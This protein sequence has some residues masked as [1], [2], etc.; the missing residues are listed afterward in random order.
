M[1][2][3]GVYIGQSIKIYDRVSGE[4]IYGRIPEGWVV[5]A[6]SLPAADG[7]DSLYYAV[8]V[9]RGDTRTRAKTAISE[10]LMD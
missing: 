7:K 10:L 4:V 8:I 6:G 2:L 1:I 9:K 3:M 5:V